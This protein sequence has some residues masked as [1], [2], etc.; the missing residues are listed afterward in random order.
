MNSNLEQYV[1]NAK[2]GD[3][4]ALD[5]VVR[6]IKD[7]IYGLALRMLG[8][9]E[10]AEDQTHEILIKVITHLSDFREESAFNTWVYK[11]ACNHLLTKRKQ[12]SSHPELTFDSF[13]KVITTVT[14]DAPPLEASDPE[15]GVLLE[16]VRLN[17]MQGSLTCLE[18]DVRIAV[19]LGEFAGVTSKEGAVILGTTPEA[20]RARLSRGR[21][22]LQKFMGSHCGL[23]NKKNAC[24]CHQHAAMALTKGKNFSKQDTIL[25]TEVAGKGRKELLA[26]L[27]E[28]SEIERTIEML[29][30]YPEYQS[31]DSFSHI[32]SGLIGSGK[33][34]IFN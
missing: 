24:K 31:P 2:S 6:S 34:K 3:Q 29:R 21:K 1:R 26:H 5:V 32:V 28:C 4:E 17:C 30:Q 22:A 14:I 10:D 16:E 18:R 7:N 25:K 9:P 12:K 23:V 19:I 11:I 20:F 8:H 15:R 27:E 13:G 33:Y